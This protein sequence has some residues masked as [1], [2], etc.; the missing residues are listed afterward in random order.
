MKQVE[1]HAPDWTTRL[2]EHRQRCEDA[3]ESW[4]ELCRRH[5]EGGHI[6]PHMRRLS[7]QIE[8]MQQDAHRLWKILYA[9]PR[10]KLWSLHRLSLTEQEYWFLRAAGFGLF[11][12]KNLGVSPIDDY[13]AYR[14]GVYEDDTSM[15][16][17]HPDETPDTVT[18]VNKKTG[19]EWVRIRL[20]QS[21]EE[22]QVRC[23][24]SGQLEFYRKYRPDVLA[25]MQ[26]EQAPDVG[27][28][29]RGGG[30]ARNDRLPAMGNDE[31]SHGL[32]DVPRR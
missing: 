29:G 28:G 11:T 24:R 13:D 23:L 30:A 21:P 20:A 17:M 31:T 8:Q 4:A 32:T 2:Q 18:V 5:D 15:C 3:A 1:K 12:A 22:C 6:G 16:F 7:K 19:R 10:N 25:R 9:T 14:V 27:D 26:P